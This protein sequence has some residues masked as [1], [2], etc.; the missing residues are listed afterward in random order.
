MSDIIRVFKL[1]SIRWAWNVARMR[2]RNICKL[3]IGKLESKILLG[4]HICRCEDNIKMD[5][6][7]QNDSVRV[8]G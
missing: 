2:I 6:L 3:S 5:N 1:R 4:L 7:I 8:K